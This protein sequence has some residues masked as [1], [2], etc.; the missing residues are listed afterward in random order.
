MAKSWADEPWTYLALDVGAALRASDDL[1]LNP[2]PLVAGVLDGCPMVG[3]DHLALV[4]RRFDPSPVRVGVLIHVG[5]RVD[6]DRLP[7]FGEALVFL[8]RPLDARLA[9][10]AI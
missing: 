5:D 6:T 10:L 7:C 1:L 2:M 3:H 4:E 9:R 8:W